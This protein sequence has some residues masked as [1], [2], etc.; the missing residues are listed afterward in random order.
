MFVTFPIDMERQPKSCRLRSLANG[1]HLDPHANTLPRDRVAEA[2]VLA[3]LRGPIDMERQPKSCRLRS[4]ANGEHLDP[5]ANTLPRYWV[6]EA[7]VLAYLRGRWPRRWL[8]GWRNVCRATDERTVIAQVFALGAVGHSHQLIFSHCANAGLLALLIANLSALVLDYTA[9]QKLGGM[10]LTHGFL[11]QFP[12][13]P[14]AVYAR[15]TPWRLG[16]AGRMAP[17]ARA[18]VDLHGL[19]PRAFCR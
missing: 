2:A 6:A 11:R 12:V 18:R 16:S 8:M 13:L 7:A 3:Y 19:G 15:M 5:H 14:P 4:L 1:E 17:A 9:R 10:N